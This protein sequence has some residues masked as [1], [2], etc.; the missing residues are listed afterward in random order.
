MNGDQVYAELE[1]LIILGALRPR[2]R[3]VE[4]EFC[5]K[6]GVSR[7]LLRE[8]LR[9]LEGIG[10]VTLHPNRGAVVRDFSPREVED[11]YF[12]RGV[13]ER[14]V[15]GLIVERVGA[16]DLRE[17]R[18]LHRQFAAACRQKAMAAMIVSNLTFHRRMSQVSGN[19]FLCQLLDISRLQTNQ[20]RYIVWMDPL[21]VRES[22]QD[23]RDMLAALAAKHRGRFETA[24]FRHVA[25][26]K[27]DYHAVYSSHW[28]DGPPGGRATP[29]A[30]RPPTR[31]IARDARRFPGAGIS[32]RTPTRKGS[33]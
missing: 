14:A 23:H 8:V 13:L 2:E 12:V 32:P 26:G 7:T 3:L 9:R 30:G 21:R 19:P 25:G 1:R 10:L 15:A 33:P 16:A 18:A 4:A 31:S 29:P 17:L 22:L 5:R 27:R 6:L 24:L 11:L 28:S 20:V